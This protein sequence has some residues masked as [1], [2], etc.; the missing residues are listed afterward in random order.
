MACS[1]FILSR[2]E[3]AVRACISLALVF[4]VCG[5]ASLSRQPET[6]RPRPNE[7]P[8]PIILAASDERRTRALGV[9]SS[10]LGEGAAQSTPAPELEPVTATLRALPSAATLRLPKVVGEEEGA[11]PTEEET[12][13]SLRR[14]IAD[15]RLLL[16]VAPEDL[17]LVERVDTS[18]GTKRAR[19]VQKPFR[20]PLRGGFGVLDIE[21]MPD[22]RIV[23]L[24]STALPDTERIARALAPVRP[25]VTP[26][27]AA[28]SLVNRSITYRDAGGREQSLTIP[29]GNS[30]TAREVVIYPRAQTE[31]PATLALHVAWEVE[32]GGT[33]PPLLVYVDALT[34]EIIGATINTATSNTPSPTPTPTP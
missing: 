12:R 33:S 26:Q 24:S 16:G 4:L 9:W 27:D 29:A 13:E 11:T 3:R 25:Q 14:F 19:Y 7:P 6:G 22:R 5:C 28:T 23:S 34:G 10:L 20:Y 30:A 17:S 31:A 1:K 18:A 32:V 15:A 21:F 2:R 8:Y